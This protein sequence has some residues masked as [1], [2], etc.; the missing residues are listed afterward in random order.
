[1]G[2]AC[3]RR[4]APRRVMKSQW[5]RAADQVAHFRCDA[6]PTPTRLAA[7]SAGHHST[8]GENPGVRLPCV[9]LRRASL[10]HPLPNPR[11]LV[12][13]AA[14]AAVEPGLYGD[15]RHAAAADAT[16]RVRVGL[17]GLRQQS[18][19]IVPPALEVS[20][21]GLPG[22]TARGMAHCVSRRAGSTVPAVA[23][24]PVV[25]RGRGPAGE[26]AAAAVRTPAI[27]ALSIRFGCSWLLGFPLLPVRLLGQVNP[28][29]NDPAPLRSSP[30]WPPAP[31][32]RQRQI[33]RPSTFPFVGNLFFKWPLFFRCAGI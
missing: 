18:S 1:M 21:A 30:I 5:H 7:V 19:A 17:Q 10:E 24:T 12:P 6:P 29:L 2:L 13:R 16:A 20:V 4:A 9:C 11:Q 14:G 8:C 23:H 28:R 31:T 25:S 32:H 15:Q 3:V 33:L 26:P 22:V 27:D